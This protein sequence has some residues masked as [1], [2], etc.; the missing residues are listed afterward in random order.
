MELRVALSGLAPA[1]A[2]GRP[3]ASTAEVEPTA[4]RPTAVSRDTV[5]IQNL[6]GFHIEVTARLMVAGSV[7][8]TITRKIGPNGATDTFSFNRHVDAFIQV[9]LRRIGGNTPP[10]F[11]TTLDQPIG[12]YYGKLF[13]VSEFGGRFIVSA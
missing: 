11:T 6:N 7:K 4:A 1:P 9:E 8:P 2:M 3:W 13:T 12:G 5:R 10:P